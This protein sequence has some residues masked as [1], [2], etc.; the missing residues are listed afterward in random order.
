M[1]ESAGGGAGG[2]SSA[3]EGVTTR[4]DDNRG[5]FRQPDPDVS[6]ALVASGAL[7][8]IAQTPVGQTSKEVME[9][10]F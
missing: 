2:A 3:G 6:R 5:E 9:G 4:A 1:G 7:G 8:P 10:S